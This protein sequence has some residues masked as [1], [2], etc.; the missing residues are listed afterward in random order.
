MKSVT[1]FAFVVLAV[2][3]VVTGEEDDLV[4]FFN[5]QYSNYSK[6][7]PSQGINDHQSMTQC[8]KEMGVDLRQEDL[9]KS[10]EYKCIFQCMLEKD[11]VLRNGVFSE[12][13]IVKL[14]KEDDDL[15]EVSKSK[16]S[17]V[18]QKCMNGIPKTPDLCEKSFELTICVYHGLSN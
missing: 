15:D 7:Y 11:G 6:L 4:W 12:D 17:E 1:T 14:I 16:A 2:V 9:E 3:L 10:P 5:S 13:Q 18:A 8:A